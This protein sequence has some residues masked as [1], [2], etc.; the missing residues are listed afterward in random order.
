MTAIIIDV[1]HYLYGLNL[2]SRA[3]E[4]MA[5]LGTHASGAHFPYTFE[6]FGTCSHTVVIAVFHAN[7]IHVVRVERVERCLQGGLRLLQLGRAERH[8]EAA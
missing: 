4:I 7:P 6:I 1:L 2:R 3:R 8:C 5:S